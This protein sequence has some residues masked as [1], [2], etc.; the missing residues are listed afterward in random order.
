MMT[1]D[2]LYL[3]LDGVFANSAKRIEE[4]TGKQYA[5][6]TPIEFWRAVETDGAFFLNL[7]RIDDSFELYDKIK[8]LPHSF[9]TGLPQNPVMVQHKRQWVEAHFGN[10]E[11][12]ATRGKLKHHY[13]TPST[14][15]IDDTARNIAL[16]HATGGIGIL[17]SSAADTLKKLRELQIVS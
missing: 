14:V 13:A 17:H 1:I 6:V 10:V 15:L 8:H 11:M 7:E 12:I 16:W 2:H 9:L 3:D 5:D 4:L